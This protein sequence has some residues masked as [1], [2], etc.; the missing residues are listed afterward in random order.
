MNLKPLGKLKELVESVG[1]GIS[2]AYE[3]LVFMDHNAFLLQFGENSRSIIVH[4]NTEANTKEAGQG[5]SQLKKAASNTD[6]NLVIGD[7]YTLS[8]DQDHNISIEFHK[9]SLT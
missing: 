8:Q 9:K 4:S 3:D 2:Y 7:F 1:M 6:L 5:I